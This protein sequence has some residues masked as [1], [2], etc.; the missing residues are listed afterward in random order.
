MNDKKSNNCHNANLFSIDKSQMYSV[1]KV[2]RGKLK[3]FYPKSC[4]FKIYVLMGKN[5][6]IKLEIYENWQF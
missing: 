5:L 3:I 4:I 1:D 2:S 6:S